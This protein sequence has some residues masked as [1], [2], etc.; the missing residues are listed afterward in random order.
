MEGARADLSNERSLIKSSGSP[1]IDHF[2]F[3]LECREKITQFVDDETIGL[4][5]FTKFVRFAT[6]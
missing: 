1:R 4:N 3:E 6:D 2:L 5:T